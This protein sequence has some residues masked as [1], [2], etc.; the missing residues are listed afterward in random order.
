MGPGLF[1]Q[2]QTVPD[3]PTFYHM[4]LSNGVQKLLDLPTGFTPSVLLAHHLPPSPNPRQ[5]YHFSGASDAAE[6]LLC[7][8]R[9][10]DPTLREVRAALLKLSMPGQQ[11][12]AE[13]WPSRRPR[14][15]S[16]RREARATSAP[17]PL[18]RQVD[19]MDPCRPEAGKLVSTVL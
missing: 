10:R 15:L 14:S 12:G 19:Q 9:V 4:P 11:P 13:N 17:G 6:F 5:P 18:T 8:Y 3:L 2:G 1:V 7:M 16:R